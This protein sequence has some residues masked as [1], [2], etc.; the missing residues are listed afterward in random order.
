MNVLIEEK[1]LAVDWVMS[2]II[3]DIPPEPHYSDFLEAVN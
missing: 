2:P 1:K 3:N